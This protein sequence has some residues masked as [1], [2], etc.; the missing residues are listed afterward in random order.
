MAVTK[1]SVSVD[2]EIAQVVRDSAA[3]D[4]VSVSAWLSEAAA[5]RIRN[6]LLGQALDALGEELGDLTDAE[7]DELV[8]QVAPVMRALLAR[9]HDDETPV[10]TTSGVVAQVWREGARQARLAVLLRGVAELPLDPDASRRIGVLLGVCGL[11]DVVDAS[12]VDI[13]RSGDE[14]LTSDTDDL[15][16]L[17]RAARKELVI[18]PVST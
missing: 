12:L 13:A 5:N 8:A 17:A 10:K 14:I 7:T 4:G 2:E 9:A 6:E 1:L 16:M 15:V 3:R 18:T 11:A